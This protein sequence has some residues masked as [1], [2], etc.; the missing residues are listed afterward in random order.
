MNFHHDEP[1]VYLTVWNEPNSDLVEQFETGF[2]D[3]AEIEVALEDL[4][5]ARQSNYLEAETPPIETYLPG[6]MGLC[7]EDRLE[8]AE[9]LLMTLG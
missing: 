2:N 6:D 5:S 4:F 1:E 7:E 9:S 3:I 8:E